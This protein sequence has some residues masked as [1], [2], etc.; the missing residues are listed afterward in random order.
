MYQ[1]NTLLFNIN[2]KIIHLIKKIV[3]KYNFNNIMFEKIYGPH[4]L[5]YD[6]KYKDLAVLSEGNEKALGKLLDFICPGEHSDKF[7]DRMLIKIYAYDFPFLSQMCSIV[8]YEANKNKLNDQLK[9]YQKI[10]NILDVS[11][12]INV[13]KMIGANTFILQIFNIGALGIIK[14]KDDLIN[15]LTQGSENELKKTIDIMI[16]GEH[17]IIKNEESLKIILINAIINISQIPN[18]MIENILLK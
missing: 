2:D 6:N 5:I 4:F 15:I 1:S 3:K 11:I 14:Y 17:E 12:K 13:E 18:Y 9:K 16:K 10:G 8:G 7:N